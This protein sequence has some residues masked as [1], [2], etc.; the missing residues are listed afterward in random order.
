MLLFGGRGGGRFG[1][2]NE[3][4]KDVDDVEIGNVDDVVVEIVVGD[5]DDDKVEDDAVGG[6]GSES[7][8]EEFVSLADAE[9][10]CEDCEIS[11]SECRCGRLPIFF[12][13]N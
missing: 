2:E 3:T 9:V 11:G 7:E 10:S 1:I 4:V 8:G 6:V 12:T 5:G 13:G